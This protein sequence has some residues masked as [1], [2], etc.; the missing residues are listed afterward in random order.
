MPLCGA[1]IFPGKRRS[2]A[3]RRAC[4]C[5]VLHAE[6]YA[7]PLTCSARLRLIDERGSACKTL[8]RGV[9]YLVGRGR[10]RLPRYTCRLYVKTSDCRAT[11]RSTIESKDYLQ[12]FLAGGIGIHCATIRIS[13]SSLPALRPKSNID[14]VT[15]LCAELRSAM[16]LRN[17]I[18]V[19]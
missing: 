14:S 1:R 8:L 16:P 2:T 6:L 15:Q 10:A 5:G 18:R 3:Q 19:K 17:H 9:V 7:K 11:L 12:R 13:N 4:K